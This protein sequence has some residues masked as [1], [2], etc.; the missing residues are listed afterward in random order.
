MPY[1]RSI[2]STLHYKPKRKFAFLQTP[3][4]GFSCSLNV[5][6]VQQHNKSKDNERTTHFGF[7]TVP[8]SEKVLKGMY[9]FSLLEFY[10]VS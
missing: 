5:G 1:C 8:E 2:W 6:Q 3:Y 7:T 4:R 10:L 9:T